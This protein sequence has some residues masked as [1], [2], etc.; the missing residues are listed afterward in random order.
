MTQAA[1]SALKASRARAGGA[2]SRF[3][4]CALAPA[5]DPLGPV[6]VLGRR[7]SR[8][9]MALGLAG[10]TTLHAGGVGAGMAQPW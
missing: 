7:A 8:L 2:A 5:D 10:A 1:S 9:G 3:L 4:A 6:F